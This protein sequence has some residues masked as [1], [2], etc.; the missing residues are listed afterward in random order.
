MLFIRHALNDKRLR[1]RNEFIALLELKTLTLIG[2]YQ[3]EELKRW[4]QLSDITLIWVPKHNGHFNKKLAD[5]LAR[6]GFVIDVSNAITL[7]TT[8]W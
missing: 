5:E 1:G 3:Q 2:P 6:T 4:G 8:K 7:A